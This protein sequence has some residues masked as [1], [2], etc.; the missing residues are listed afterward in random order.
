[1][2]SQ[3]SKTPNS[4]LTYPDPTDKSRILKGPN[5]STDAAWKNTSATSNNFAGATSKAGLELT[6]CHYMEG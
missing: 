2:Q 4:I 6:N 3:I 5:I 1:M